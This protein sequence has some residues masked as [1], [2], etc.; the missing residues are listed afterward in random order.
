M[1]ERY[2]IFYPFKAWNHFP[3]LLQEGFS[4]AFSLEGKGGKNLHENKIQ[5]KLAKK[6]N[7]S[8]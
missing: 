8:F 5:K 1:A 3:W 2:Y 7:I 6:E 4:F